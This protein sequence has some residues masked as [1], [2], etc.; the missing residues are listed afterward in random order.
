MIID[1][2][3]SLA[4]EILTDQTTN[5]TNRGSG[6]DPTEGAAVHATLSGD[7]ASVQSLIA[8]AMQT[9]AVRLS[10]IDALRTSVSSGT[11]AIDTGEIA[12][13]LLQPTIG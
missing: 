5:K 10:R 9:P 3:G 1:R 8:Q 12:S 4:N 2:I 6:A 11:Y 13:A 7:T